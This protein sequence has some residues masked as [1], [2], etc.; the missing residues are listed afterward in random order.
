[1]QVLTALFNDQVKR[2][3]LRGPPYYVTASI[4]PTSEAIIVLAKY[5]LKE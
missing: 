3:E 2:L 1:M 5:D 4:V